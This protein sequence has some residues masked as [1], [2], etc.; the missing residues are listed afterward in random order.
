MKQ[1]VKKVYSGNT[2]SY[3]KLKRQLDPVIKSK[4]CK[5]PN[6]KLDMAATM[7]YDDVLDN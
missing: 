6:I 5:F 7:P 3:I 2:D 1:T 4:P